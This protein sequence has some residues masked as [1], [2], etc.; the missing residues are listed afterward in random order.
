[1]ILN[2]DSRQLDKKIEKLQRELGVDNLD[3]DP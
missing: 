2:L 1:M 3:I